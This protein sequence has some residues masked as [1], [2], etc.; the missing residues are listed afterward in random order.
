MKAACKH[1]S[2]PSGRHAGKPLSEHDLCRVDLLLRVQPSFMCVAEPLL[3]PNVL[4]LGL[5]EPEVL[6]QRV[7]RDG[8]RRLQPAAVAAAAAGG[9][10]EQAADPLAHTAPRSQRVGS[11]ACVRV[12]MELRAAPAVLCLRR[13]TDA[14]TAVPANQLCSVRAAGGACAACGAAPSVPAPCASRESN[15]SWQ[16]RV[17]VWSRHPVD[18]AAAACPLD[19]TKRPRYRVRC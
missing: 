5:P 9:E 3:Q 4:K 13:A 7:L 12:S 11:C 17:C 6:Q 15:L 8:A 10:A 14:A 19:R 1:E 18:A 16:P 2:N